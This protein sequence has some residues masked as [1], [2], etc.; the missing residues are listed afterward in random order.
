MI[1][2]KFIVVDKTRSLFLK[3]G[4]TFYLERV[5]RYAKSRWTE[6]KPVRIKKGVT[7]EEILTLEGKRILASVR[8][9]DYLACLDRS[10][11]QYD[12]E[13]L[14]D[15]LQQLSLKVRGWL[16]LAIGGPLGIGRSVLERS[17]KVLSLSR[18]TFTHEMSRMILLEQIYRALT[19]L[20]GENYH[21]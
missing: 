14:A 13:G 11:H 10:G 18:L 9:G 5:R 4:E 12:S 1:R 16:C 3:E 17:E 15:W 19:I 21:K 20:R 8:E 6:V 2:L 7:D